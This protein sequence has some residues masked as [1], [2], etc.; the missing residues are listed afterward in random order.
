MKRPIQPP[1]K[2]FTILLGLTVLLYWSVYLRVLFEEDII[3]V[4]IENSV[5]EVY[6]NEAVNIP[7]PR[8]KHQPP[9]EQVPETQGNSIDQLETET[10]PMTDTSTSN[11]AIEKSERWAG[12]GLTVNIA[13]EEGEPQ[14]QDL[15]E[16]TEQVLVKQGY[17]PD[18]HR[19]G[20]KY[21]F[22]QP[23]GGWGNQRF[24]IRWAM[25]VA[26]AMNR[27]LAMSPLAAHSDI[28][29]GYN[30]WRKE[31]LLPADKV[32]DVRALDEAI[33]R[34]VVFLDDIP[35]RIVQRIQN[36]TYMTVRTHVKGHYVNRERKRLLIYKEADIRE[37]WLSVQEDV[38]FWDKMSMWQCCTT[39]FLPDTVW[40]GR[41]IMFNQAFKSLARALTA[42]LGPY[43]AVHVRRGD[44][45]I[46]KDRRTAEVYYKVH[47]LDAFD[48]TLPLYIATNEKDLSWFDAL[49]LPGRFTKL[50]FWDDLN[51]NLL[52][53][54]LTNFPQAMKGDILGFIDMLICGNAVKWEG[55]RKSTFSAAISS[56]RVSPPLRSLHW[57][58]P[59]KPSVRKGL[60]GENAVFEETKEEGEDL[61]INGEEDP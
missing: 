23:S 46:S 5:E 14:E 15:I 39:D 3:S 59:P 50:V 36:E 42:H 6:I 25:M 55:S 54:T 34:G 10:S 43:N 35:A 22:Y 32:L 28:W 12:E 30:Q 38:V 48:K 1:E 44:M 20:T 2:S 8:Q 47:R 41:H 17:F 16:G 53:E 31:D 52:E 40:Y 58:F 27:T 56:I 4:P 61:I 24:I 51:Q 18:V 49:K 33:D 45:T 29:T 19:K 21:F 13:V 11:E 60:Q 37:S 57:E 9:L 7:I 26:N